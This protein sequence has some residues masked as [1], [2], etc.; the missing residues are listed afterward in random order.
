[1]KW[2]QKAQSH[3]QVTWLPIIYNYYFYLLP[4]IYPATCSLQPATV[5]CRLYNHFTTVLQPCNLTVISQR[6]Q[7]FY[8]FGEVIGFG[9]ATWLWNGCITVTWSHGDI[10][11]T[12][13]WSSYNGFMINLQLSRLAIRYYLDR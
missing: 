5:L 1:M 4:I 6:G 12:V 13:V 3:D 10:T 2:N 11:I 8:L 9:E 7:R